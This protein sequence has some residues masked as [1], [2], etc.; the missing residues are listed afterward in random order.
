M[1]GIG[2]G[3]R[4]EHV[5]VRHDLYGDFVE[6]LISLQRD[7]DCAKLSSRRKKANR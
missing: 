1:L 3:Y 6:L 2:A 5:A 4:R 7:R